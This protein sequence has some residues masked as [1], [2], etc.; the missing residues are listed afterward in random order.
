MGPCGQGSVDIRRPSRREHPYPEVPEALIADCTL[1]TPLGH[2]EVR[3]ERHALNSCAEHCT[4]MGVI[5]GV[6]V[7]VLMMYGSHVQPGDSPR[8]IHISQ[9][10]T[11]G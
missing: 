11:T 7:V 5:S 4:G 9:T 8:R 10:T 6:L 2:Q 1:R 3:E